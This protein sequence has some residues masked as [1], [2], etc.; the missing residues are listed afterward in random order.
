MPLCPPTSPHQ[1]APAFVAVLPS[2]PSVSLINK[3]ERGV[4]YRE[5]AVPSVT[6]PRV[7]DRRGPW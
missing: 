3:T 5:L 4:I 7:E 1:S 2:W 6:Q